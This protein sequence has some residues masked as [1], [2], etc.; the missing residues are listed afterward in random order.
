MD[1]TSSYVLTPHMVRD[2]LSFK[3]P[4]TLDDMAHL[5]DTTKEEVLVVATVALSR[6]QIQEKWV[7][8]NLEQIKIYYTMWSE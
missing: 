2:N 8:H 4:M 1:P 5:F 3:G 7:I 6:G